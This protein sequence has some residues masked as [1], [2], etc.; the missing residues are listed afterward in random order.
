VWSEGVD[1]GD[2][3]EPNIFWNEERRRAMLIDFDRAALRPAVKH[4][5]LS[6]LSGN[7]KKRKRKGDT[8]EMHGQKRTIMGNSLR[9]G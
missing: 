4:K 7:G 1:H 2:E 5:Q 8:P 3:P 9:L 6:T